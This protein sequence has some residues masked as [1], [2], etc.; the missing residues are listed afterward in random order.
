MRPGEL[1]WI[2]LR[3]AR[4]APIVTSQSATLV[5]GTGIEGDRYKTQRNGARQVTLI[6]TSE[7][8]VR[9]GDPVFY[10]DRMF[11]TTAFRSAIDWAASAADL[12]ARTR[13]SVAQW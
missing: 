8:P 4:R 3:P 5:A 10:S 1:I 2:G 13:T 11:L 12:G 9:R 7:R 6:A